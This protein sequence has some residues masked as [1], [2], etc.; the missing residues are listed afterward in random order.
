MARGPVLLEEPSEEQEDFLQAAE[1]R[2]LTDIDPN[3]APVPQA[4]G[5]NV[6]QGC[7]RPRATRGC[8]EQGQE[9]EC[10]L[11]GGD[12]AGGGGFRWC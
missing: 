12:S 3:E 7:Q 5:P 9:S 11:Q 1:D 10:G 4:A 8:A 6:P 2:A